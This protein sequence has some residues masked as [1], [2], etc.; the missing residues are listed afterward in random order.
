MTVPSIGTGF[1]GPDGNTGYLLRQ[2]FQLFRAAMEET[3]REVGLTASQYSLLS[4]IDSQPGYSAAQLAKATVMTEQSVG[5]LLGSLEKAGWVERRREHADRRVRLVHLTTAG[6]RVVAEATP[7]VRA[8]EYRMTAGLSEAEQRQF[9]TWLAV[10]ACNL[11][12]QP[13]AEGAEGA[14]GTGRTIA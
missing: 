5:E 13:A 11:A 1:R 7:R 10:A 6:S 3:L 9:R 12:G 4:A 8:V 14:E 2:T